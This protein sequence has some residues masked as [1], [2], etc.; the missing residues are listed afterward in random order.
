MGFDLKYPQ[1]IWAYAFVIA[2]AI[3]FILA[4]RKKDRIMSILKTS[5][6][7]RLKALRATLL[8]AG[9]SLAAFALLGPQ[10]FAGYSEVNK[11]GLD[12][13]FLIDTSK[14]MLVK[15]ITPDRIT[16]AKNAVKVLINS[17]DGD[18]VGF[19][20]FAS[21]AYIQMPLTDDYELARMFLDVIDTDMIG[22]GGTNIAA[23][24]RLAGDSFE[25]ASGGDKIII[26]VSDGEEHDGEGI[27]AIG[28][29]KDDRVKIYAIGVGTEMGGLV[30]VYDDSGGAIVDYMK[31]ASDNP[32]TSRLKSDTMRKLAYEGHGSYF[33]ATI[34]G[35]E[36][37]ALKNELSSLKKG[38]FSVE[39][40]KRFNPLFQ[41]FLG[42]GLFLFMIAWL[43][44]ERRSI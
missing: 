4:L 12:I 13:Y 39:K 2:A 8:C 25:R 20:P 7:A 43:L 10:A 9:L 15:D 26:V 37:L 27:D 30:P 14:S 6:S 28:G 38:D 5:Y 31:D 16:V 22:G 32:V 44:P 34:S 3:F 36:L 18:R 40:V 1:N 17:L 33:Q 41:Y 35:D 19:I 11:S 21:D 23:A 24:L 29:I 42:A